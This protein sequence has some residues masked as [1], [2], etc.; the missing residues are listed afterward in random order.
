MALEGPSSGIGI[1][2]S[3]ILNIAAIV[4]RLLKRM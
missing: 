1:G 2:S 4:F 3:T